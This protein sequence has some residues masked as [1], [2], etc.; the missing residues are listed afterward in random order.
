MNESSMEMQ[1]HAV[2]AWQVI[3]NRFGPIV[4]ST[5]LI[6]SIAAIIT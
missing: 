2:D 5:L 3:K 4:L 6:F 1:K